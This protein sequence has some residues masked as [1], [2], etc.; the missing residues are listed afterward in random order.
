MKVQQP[1]NGKIIYL[2]KLWTYRGIIYPGVTLPDQLWPGR[3]FYIHFPFSPSILKYPKCRF[4]LEVQL[5]LTANGWILNNGYHINQLI[6]SLKLICICIFFTPDAD[7][8]KSIGNKLPPPLKPNSHAFFKLSFI[9][10]LWIYSGPRM[11]FHTKGVLSFTV[12]CFYILYITLCCCI[13]KVYA[14]E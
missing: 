10:L 6:K 8:T 12:Y 13:Y 7:L 9:H 14:I 2:F 4:I 5:I 1:E 3:K 11:I